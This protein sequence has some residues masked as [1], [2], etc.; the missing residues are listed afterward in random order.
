MTV[1]TVRAQIDDEQVRAKAGK[2]YVRLTKLRYAGGVS[3]YLEVLDSERQLY[4]AQMDYT[5][6]RLTQLQ[7]AVQLYRALGGGWADAPSG[8]PAAPISGSGEQ[9]AGSGK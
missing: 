8:P 2:E 7:A 3:S 9:G 6:A 1:Q 5:S 4:S